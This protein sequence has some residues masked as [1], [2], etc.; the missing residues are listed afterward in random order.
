MEPRPFASRSTQRALGLGVAG[1]LLAV[2]LSAGAPGCGSGGTTAT[3]GHTTS[4]SSTTG[5]S[6][7]TGGAGTTTVSSSTTG[8]GGATSSSSTTGSGGAGGS[9][10]GGSVLWTRTFTMTA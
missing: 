4:A 7:S 2:A 10:P 9:A 5:T 3:G 6:S 1:G 8:T